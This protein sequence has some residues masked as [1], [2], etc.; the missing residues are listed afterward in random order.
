MMQGFCFHLGAGGRPADRRSD[1]RG[2]REMRYFF[3]G[4]F[5]G[6]LRI[7]IFSVPLR[8]FSINNNGRLKISKKLRDCGSYRRR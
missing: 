4:A 2:Y 7:G 3:C 5:P 1:V 8:N 6:T